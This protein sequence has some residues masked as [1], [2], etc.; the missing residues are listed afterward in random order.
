M[1][2][3]TSALGAR[4]RDGA[5]GAE[6]GRCCRIVVLLESALLVRTGAGGRATT[7]LVFSTTSA[8]TIGDDD[9]VA[10]SPAERGRA[11]PATIVK[12]PR[13]M[14]GGGTSEVAARRNRG[15]AGARQQAR[16]GGA[17]FPILLFFEAS[18][19][20]MLTFF[21]LRE[22]QIRNREEWRRASLV[23]R[24]LAYLLRDER[25]GKKKNRWPSPPGVAEGGRRHCR[26]R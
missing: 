8:A 13:A 26:R 22:E 15:R 16:F 20:P 23:V 21:F 3:A 1:P 25:K 10:A 5:G 19:L 4:W 24:A 12:A 14:R 18:F 2:A 11:V 17:E 9:G 7:S 6:P